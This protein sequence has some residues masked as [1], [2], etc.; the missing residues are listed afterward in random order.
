[1]KITVKQLRAIIKEE[2]TQV[3]SQGRNIAF[4]PGSPNI[5]SG[6]KDFADF[7][8]RVNALGVTLE[9]FKGDRS[10]AYE[11]MSGIYNR[12]FDTLTGAHVEM[13]NAIVKGDL[14]ELESLVDQAPEK[15]KRGDDWKQAQMNSLRSLD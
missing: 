15:I 13:A 8:R 9:E 12:P 10:G 6:P 3:L 11:L 7:M 2:V 4:K 14:N 5:Y 1:M